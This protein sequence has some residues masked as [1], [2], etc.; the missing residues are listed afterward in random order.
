M[1]KEIY[2]LAFIL[3]FAIVNQYFYTYYPFFDLLYSL[4]D[5]P[6]ILLKRREK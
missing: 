4:G 1:R 2:T 6:I 5:I 3:L